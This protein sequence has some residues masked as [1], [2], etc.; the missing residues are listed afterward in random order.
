MDHR[1]PYVSDA[2]RGARGGFDV[3]SVGNWLLT[4]VLLA[5]PLVNLVALL[6]WAFAGAVHPSKRTFAQAGLILTVISASFYLLLLFTGTAVPLT[7]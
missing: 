7:P 3:I 2:P 5:I 1:D 6:Y 4:L